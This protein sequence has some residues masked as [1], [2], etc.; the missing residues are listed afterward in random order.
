MEWAP[1][2][3]HPARPAAAAPA[4]AAKAPLRVGDELDRLGFGRFQVRM[5]LVLGLANA[6]DGKAARCVCGRDKV[7]FKMWEPK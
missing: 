4:A 1:S 6:A 5:L 2:P 3:L 7:V